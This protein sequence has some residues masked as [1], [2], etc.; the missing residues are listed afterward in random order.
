[1][2][3]KRDIKSQETFIIIIENYTKS[4]TDLQYTIRSKT[5]RHISYIGGVTIIKARMTVVE[6]QIL[7]VYRICLIK[8]SYVSVKKYMQ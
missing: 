8:I 4:F 3:S 2:W 5:V 6:V 1:M 7:W